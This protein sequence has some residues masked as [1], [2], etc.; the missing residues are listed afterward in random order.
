MLKGELPNCFDPYLRYAIWT[1]FKNFKF[2]ADKKLFLFVELKDAERWRSSR[3]RW[4]IPTLPSEFGPD[5]GHTRYATLR[6]GKRGG[7]C[8]KAVPYLGQICLQSR[9]IASSEAI[10]P[11]AFGKIR[12]KLSVASGKA[13]IRR[14]RS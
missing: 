8:N 3:K 12:G 9:A 10:G 2:S 11:R 14:G 7:A 6:A 4:Q 5:V 1:R 13:K